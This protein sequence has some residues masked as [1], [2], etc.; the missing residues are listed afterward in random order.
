MLCHAPNLAYRVND[1]VTGHMDLL[2]RC[3]NTSEQRQRGGGRFLLFCAALV[4]P[5][6]AL[7]AAAPSVSTPAQSLQ[8]LSPGPTGIATYNQRDGAMPFGVAVD[9]AGAA[10]TPGA[11]VFHGIAKGMRNV[12]VVCPAGGKWYLAQPA[13]DGRFSVDV[14]VPDVRGPMTVDVYSWDSVPNDPNYKTNIDASFDVFVVGSTQAEKGTAQAPSPAVGMRLVW[15]DEFTGPLS[16]SGARHRDAT[17]FAGGKPS[18]TGSQYSDALFVPAQDKRNPFFIKDGFLRIRATQTAPDVDHPASWWSGHLS[19]GFP[20]E[21]ASFEFRRGYAEVRMKTPVGPGPWPAFWL[22]DSASTLPS[23]TYGAV[24][25][26]AV[27]AY[28]HDPKWY[29]A[30]LHRWPNAEGN[31]P[32]QYVAKQVLRDPN[33]TGGFHTYG[34][35]LTDVDVIWYYDGSEVYRSPLFRSDVVSPFYIMIDL[36]MGGGWPVVTPPAGYYDLWLDYVRVYE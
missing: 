25:I 1:E 19:T 6:C 31:E 21:S 13:E 7:A 17:W 4:C 18:S 34:V 16:F 36:A 30:T 35:R 8:M 14:D 5:G 3:S 2:A 22:L 24:E 20:D 32:H 29:M 15:S 10:I 11:H 9:D 28:G 33:D 12:A 23:R 26:D 27:E